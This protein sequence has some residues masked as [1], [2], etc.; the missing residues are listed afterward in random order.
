M[1][2]S[3]VMRKREITYCKLKKI[4]INKFTQDLSDLADMDFKGDKLY[5][6][7]SEFESKLK[8]TLDKHA[9]EVTKKIME[10]KKQ[11]WFDEN[12]KKP[13]EIYA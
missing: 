3:T 10:R 5:C 13:E 7:V 2:Q 9:P 6:I 4:D 12:I 11:P 8:W 1:K